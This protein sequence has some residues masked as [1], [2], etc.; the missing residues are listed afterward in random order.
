[1]KRINIVRWLL[2]GCAAGTGPYETFFFTLSRSF[3]EIFA[4]IW[5]YPVWNIL[6]QLKYIQ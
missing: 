1:M 5:V 6:H 2:G 3:P 4:V